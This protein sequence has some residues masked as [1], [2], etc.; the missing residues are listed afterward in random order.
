MYPDFSFL[1][2]WIQLVLRYVLTRTLL[3]P[4]PLG[5]PDQYLASKW[6]LFPMGNKKWI[7]WAMT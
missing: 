1:S 5:S 6:P 4:H 2:L 7:E 3:C